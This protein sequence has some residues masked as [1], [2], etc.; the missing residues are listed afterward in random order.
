M[1]CACGHVKVRRVTCLQP[2]QTRARPTHAATSNESTNHAH[3]HLKRERAPRPRR[4]QTHHTPIQIGAVRDKNANGADGGVM[5]R[6]ARG[7]VHWARNRDAAR[8]A[9][10]RALLRPS[11]RTGLRPG[12][13]MQIPSACRQAS[14]WDPRGQA[15]EA[16]RFRRW[17]VPPRRGTSC[18]QPP[19]R[20]TR[21]TKRR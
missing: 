5:C 9:A 14:P 12:L 16:L 8:A 4:P 1:F 11:H 10:K 18:Q 13:V 15:R 2:H 17:S 19:G 21:Q 20:R 6:S 3:G 7:A